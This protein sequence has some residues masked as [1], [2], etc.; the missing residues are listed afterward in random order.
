[1]LRDTLKIEK[2]LKEVTLWVHPEGKVVGALFV[3]PQSTVTAREEEP[4]EVLNE[5]EPFVVVQ[6]EGPEDIRFYSK[7][8]VVRVE[9]H[10]TQPLQ[11]PEI[12]PLECRLYLMDGSIIE[13]TIRQ[14]LPPERARLF[15]YLNRTEERFVKIAGGDGD[16]C[17]VN[18]AYIVCVKP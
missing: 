13:G 16:I 2:T 4:A 5:H 10:A 7:S 9:Y 3:R 8:S 15:D 1:M 6:V 14:P 11:M 18:K 17:L 12:E